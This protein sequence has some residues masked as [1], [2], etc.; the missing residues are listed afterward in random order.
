MSIHADIHYV[1]WNDRHFVNPKEY[2][3]ERY[4]SEDGASLRKVRREYRPDQ[5]QRISITMC[6]FPDRHRM[7]GVH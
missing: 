5:N 6:T 2:R 1:M 4:I 3:P 7:I